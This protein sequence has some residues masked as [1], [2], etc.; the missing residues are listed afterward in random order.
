MFVLEFVKGWLNLGF[1]AV[2][3]VVAVVVI[4]FLEFDKGLFV[5]LDVAEFGFIFFFGYSSLAWSSSYF[6][7]RLAFVSSSL[8]LPLYTIVVKV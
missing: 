5:G 6:L 7:F 1:V 4:E 2:V 3:V 8:S